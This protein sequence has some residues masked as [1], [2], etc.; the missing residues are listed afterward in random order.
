V[1][2][3]LER[4]LEEA[5]ASEFKA[6]YVQFHG[7]TWENQEKSEFSS[8]FLNPFDQP[9]S[10]AEVE[11]RVEPYFYSPSGSSWPVLGR[12]LPFYIYW[13]RIRKEIK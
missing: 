4:M 13:L 12:P 10:S 5:V 3:E 9:P 8:G 7:E 6:F 1:N 2:D 11:E